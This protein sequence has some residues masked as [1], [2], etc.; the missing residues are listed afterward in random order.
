MGI[1]RTINMIRNLENWNHHLYYKFSAQKSP[2][3]E[4]RLRKH[5]ATRVPRM[6][7]H[8][9]K[10]SVFDEVYVKNLPKSI[11]QVNS[12][13]IIDIGANVGYF[14]LYADFKFKNPQI[15]SFEPVRRNFVLLQDNLKDLDTSRIHII[16]KGV[17]DT[18]GEIV[19]KFNN[20]HDITTSASI[21]DNQ[22][23]SDEERVASVTL[24]GL[25]KEY[26]LT[27]IDLL[28][29]DCEGA[30]YGIFY[31]TPGQVFDAVNCIA[32]ETHQGPAGNEN[33]VALAGYLEGLGFRVKHRP[34][35][36]WA[37]KSPEFWR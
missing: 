14:T 13:V 9:F 21:F 26:N 27:K 35:F 15:F 28:K 5:S 2:F 12:P 4:F 23:G 1:R 31:N 37:Y 24:P 3:F 11:L 34:F 36:I 8:E 25:M 10:E 32:L 17:S 7:Q 29:L 20:D 22:H 33:T 18:E 6:V 30:E 19:L 16:N